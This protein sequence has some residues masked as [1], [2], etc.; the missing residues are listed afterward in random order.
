M[1]TFTHGFQSPFWAKDEFLHWYLR[2]NLPCILRPLVDCEF[3]ELMSD[4]GPDLPVVDV[5]SIGSC[6]SLFCRTFFHFCIFSF[7]SFSSCPFL[8]FFSLLSVFLSFVLSFF[9]SFFLP[10]LS[11]YSF[12][13]SCPSLEIGL[14]VVLF[15]ICL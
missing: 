10:S 14:A 5:S 6:L 2:K 1:K 9:L 15:G 3:V 7:Y 13:S 12:L 11:K 8:A 4:E